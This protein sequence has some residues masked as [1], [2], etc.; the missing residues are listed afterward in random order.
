[1][2]EYAHAMGN[3]PGAFKEYWDAI[4]TYPRAAGG[5]VWDWVDQGLA[6]TTDD[7][8]VW[9]AYGGDYGDEP[10]DG[11]FC[12]NGLIWPDRDAASFALGVE[13]DAGT[14][15]RGTCGLGGGHRAHHQP[16][17]FHR[18]ERLGRHLVA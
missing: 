14:C 10:N 11:N 2:C 8:E 3:S 16:L 15:A 13:E 9:F 6:R 1:M 5:F 18:S 7:G 4:E 17:R 12:I